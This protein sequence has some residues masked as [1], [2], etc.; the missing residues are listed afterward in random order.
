VGGRGDLGSADSLQ[1]GVTLGYPSGLSDPL[2][3]DGASVTDVLTTVDTTAISTTTGSSKQVTSWQPPTVADTT[4]AAFQSPTLAPNVVGSPTRGR[5][6][7]SSVTLS[8]PT[9]S[10][11][12]GFEQSQSVPLSGGRAA[13]LQRAASSQ[14]RSE[15]PPSLSPTQWTG[16]YGSPSPPIESDIESEYPAAG[17]TV[18]RPWSTAEDQVPLQVGANIRQLGSATDPR[19]Y[20]PEMATLAAEVQPSSSY[21][22]PTYTRS[23]TATFSSDMGQRSFEPMHIDVAAH[24]YVSPSVIADVAPLLLQPDI[25]CQLLCLGLVHLASVNRSRQCLL[26]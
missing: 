18:Y 7:S 2:D 26:A 12:P 22:A 20:I 5:R 14:R 24:S 17:P 8:P 11:A 15:R 3:S 25:N 21:V 13:S 16:S 23:Y 6:R 10:P 19:I 1:V 4:A 9:L